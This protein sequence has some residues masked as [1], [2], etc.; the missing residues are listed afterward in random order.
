MSYDS[1][2][3]K[4][5]LQCKGKRLLVFR[6]R[7]VVFQGLVRE[8]KIRKLSL[9]AAANLGMELYFRNK[10]RDALIVHKLRGGSILAAC[11][12]ALR[13]ERNQKR[14]LG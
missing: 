9:C 3:V 6:A 14:A 12:E 4:I 8:A 2:D 7:R 11:V 13:E 1:D 10:P 5:K